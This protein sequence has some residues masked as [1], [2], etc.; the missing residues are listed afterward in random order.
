MSP[1]LSSGVLDAETKTKPITQVHTSERTELGS[2]LSLIPKS[3]VFP[4]NSKGERTS[5]GL[6]LQLDKRKHPRFIPELTRLNR[7]GFL[8]A[9]TPVLPVRH[10]SEA[11]WSL[12]TFLCAQALWPRGRRDGW[13]RAQRAPWGLPFE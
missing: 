2:E 6:S 7:N 13:L 3:I 1:G 11:H 9:V 5:G 12:P 8:M 4:P 10:A